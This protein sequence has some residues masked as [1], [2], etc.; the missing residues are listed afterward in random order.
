MSLPKSPDWFNKELNGQQ[1]GRTSR[2]GQ[3]SGNEARCAKEMPTRQE[4]RR[5]SDILNERKLKCRAA[6]Q[7]VR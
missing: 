6:E 4:I 3:K 1:L 2:Q 5:K 7:R